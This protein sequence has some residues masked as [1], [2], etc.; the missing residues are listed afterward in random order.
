MIKDVEIPIKIGI[1]PPFEGIRELG[2]NERGHLV[3]S[4]FTTPPDPRGRGT[5]FTSFAISP[6]EYRR[7]SP[8]KAGFAR[9]NKFLVIYDDWGSPEKIWA[10]KSILDALVADCIANGLPLI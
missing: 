3:A 7:S 10:P 2:F 9:G 4:M 5:W 8:T 1:H 6:L